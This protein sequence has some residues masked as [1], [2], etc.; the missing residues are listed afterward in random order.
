MRGSYGIEYERNNRDMAFQ[1]YWWVALSIPIFALAFFFL[2]GCADTPDALDNPPVQNTQLDIPKENLTPQRQS[3]WTHFVNYWT[4]KE[5]AETNF[6]SSSASLPEEAAMTRQIAP[7]VRELLDKANVAEQG[8]N[9][10][11]ARQLL[12][13]LLNMEDASEVRPFIERKLG[14]IHTQLY[15][16]TRPAPGK[17]THRLASGERIGKLALQYGCPLEYLLY[18]NNIQKP[19]RL[20]IG[21]MITVLEN[22]AFELLISKRD[23]TAV[24]LLNNRFFKRYTLLLRE[25]TPPPKGLYRVRSRGRK[26]LEETDKW[27]GVA[28]D[29]PRYERDICWVTLVTE[30]GSTS[31]GI[32][33]QGTRNPQAKQSL[34]IRFRNTDIEELYFLLPAKTPVIV[35]D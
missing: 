10:V 14:A 4:Q 29:K 26:T 12:F 21:K 30:E 33:L 28:D 15:L 17:T 18:V 5:N 16:S 23:S 32:T 13:R 7:E 24:L 11:E 31:G 9:L 34:N 25:G 6:S 8:N 35:A 19:E 20:Q 3:I 22:P 1:R 27:R 2:R